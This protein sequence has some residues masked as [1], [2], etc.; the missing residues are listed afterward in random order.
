IHY[1]LTREKDG[2]Y[3]DFQSVRYIAQAFSDPFVYNGRF[4]EHR[5]RFHGSDTEG[6]T[7]SD[8]VVC[9]QNHDQVGNRMLGERISELASDQRCLMAAC[10]YILSPYTPMIFMGE[11]Y[12][13]RNP[14]LFFV[15]HSDDWL[16]EAVRKGRRK[17]FRSFS[18]KGE[19]P[20][21]QDRDTFT[22]SMLN[23]PDDRRSR[24]FRELYREVI[25]IR[26]RK[27][28]PL[29]HKKAEFSAEVFEDECIR[30]QINT[31]EGCLFSYSNWGSDDVEVQIKESVV[32]STGEHSLSVLSPGAY[33][34]TED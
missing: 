25:D 4:S 2:Y 32:F 13:E 28:I 14:F 34:L 17:E 23:D 26:R 15:S 9:I 19:P 30:T 1:G 8:F 6:T 22:G 18:W 10:F 27:I 33:I 3:E 12:G 20:D 16:I 5:Q 11:E 21:P 29:L 31:A 24:K 7:P